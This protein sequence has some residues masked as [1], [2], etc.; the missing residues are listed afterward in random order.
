M[1]ESA[2]KTVQK[3]TDDMLDHIFMEMDVDENNKIN[4]DEFIDM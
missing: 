3:I 4:S 2:K 1:L